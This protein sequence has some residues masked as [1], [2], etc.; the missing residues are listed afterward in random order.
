LHHIRC[1]T[2]AGEEEFFIMISVCRHIKPDGAR[3]KAAAL[4]G[5]PYCYHH[6]HL[7]RVLNSR[8][9]SKKNSLVLHPLEDRASVLMAL[10]DVICGLASGR[11]DSRNAGRLI[12]GLQVAGRFAPLTSGWVAADAVKSVDFTKTGDELAPKLTLCTVDDHCDSCPDCED[13]DLK[14][15]IAWRAARDAEDD[16][17]EDESADEDDDS[18]EGDNAANAA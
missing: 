12:Y 8:K 1:K 5:M 13:C 10:S 18:G 6:D 3:C 2:G 7:H 9:S 14:K 17:E 11:I 16:E 15:A 4:R